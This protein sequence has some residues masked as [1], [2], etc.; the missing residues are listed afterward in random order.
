MCD[1]EFFYFL[2]ALIIDIN[3]LTEEYIFHDPHEFVAPGVVIA[4]QKVNSPDSMIAI[5]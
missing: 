4:V 3:I 1:F 5:L 2:V